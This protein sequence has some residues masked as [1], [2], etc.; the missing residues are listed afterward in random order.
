MNGA[1]HYENVEAFGVPSWAKR[2]RVVAKVGDHTFF[3]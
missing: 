2:M 3:R 1:T